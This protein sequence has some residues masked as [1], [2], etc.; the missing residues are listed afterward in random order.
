MLVKPY[1]GNFVE[2]PRA[3]FRTRWLTLGPKPK[4]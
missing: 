2:N 4:K 1:I 3:I